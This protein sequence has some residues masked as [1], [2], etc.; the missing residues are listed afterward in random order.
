LAG[1]E[2]ALINLIGSGLGQE[3]MIVSLRSD[4]LA[5]QASLP[6]K[7]RVEALGL[8]QT[9][10]IQAGRKLAAIA[11]DY[12][13]SAIIGWMYHGNI[14]ASLLGF[15]VLRSCPIVWTVHH[16]LDDLSSESRSTKLAIAG[17]ALVSR[18]ADAIVYMSSRAQDQHRRLFGNARRSI[19]IP[20]FV[21]VERLA[22]EKARAPGKTVGFAARYHPTKDFQTFIRTV[23]LVHVHDPSVRFIAC[24]QGASMDN[25][26]LTKLAQQ[27]GL[28][29]GEIEWLG[30]RDNMVEFYDDLDLLLLTSRAEGFGMVLAEAIGHGV[31]CVTTDVGAAREI[32][33]D[34]GRIAP[35]G[36]ANALASAILDELSR[37]EADRRARSKG[38]IEH[39]EANFRP[40]L[41][42]QRYE[43][44][45]SNL[46]RK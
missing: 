24:G 10:L 26:D 11:S 23:R 39:F 20:N 25:A 1:A 38:A 3:N 28:Q 12:Q 36:D 5:Q 46:A 8:P 43:S 14:A 32:V 21:Q 9:S 41:I 4:A 7:C 19:V 6:E 45:L 2:Q 30:P 15:G 34:N 35:V 17:S 18:T 22:G 16:A 40:A 33:G 27:E 13:P 29:P 37:T 31:P 44:L 42:R